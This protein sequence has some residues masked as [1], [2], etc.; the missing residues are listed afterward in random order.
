MAELLRVTGLKKHF[1]VT[2]GL[3]KREVARV[4]AV[5]GV[6]F[7]INEGETFGLVGESGC[8]KTTVGKVVLR[9]LDATEGEIL[10]KGQDITK[11]SK[12][13]MRDLR[14]DLQIVFQDPYGSLNP[15]MT[16]HDIIAEPMKKHNICSGEALEKRVVELLNRVGL[17]ERELKKYPH[18]FSGGQR[19]RIG[20]ARAMV[21]E[22]E[23]VI[24]D[25]PI[26]AL[27]VSVQSQILNLFKELQQELG[28]AYLFIAHG[29]PVVKYMSDRVG[30]MYLGKLVEIGGSEEIYLNHLHPYTEALLSSVPIPDPDL[31]KEKQPIILQG[32]IPSPIAPPSGCRFRTRCPYAMD[33]CAKE[34]PCM[35]EVGENHSVA[36]H[37]VNIEKKQQ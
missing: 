37:R 11:L 14:Q 20:I 32:D 1:P 17:S 26:S 25:E 21:M 33:I 12:K 10:Y 19:Q 9:L 31:A 29:M 23:L 5:D 4:K 22:P 15:R 28:I 16:V 8:G 27:D 7:V 3:L 2:K 35:V 24:A 13:E 18:E 6:D 30:V 36:C 34:E